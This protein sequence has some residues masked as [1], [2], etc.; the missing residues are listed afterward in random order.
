MAWTWTLSAAPVPTTAFLTSRAAYSPT[1]DARA[2]GDHQHDAA[3]LGEL[4]RR[5]RVLVDEDFLGRRAVRAVVDEH[6]LELRRE[7]GEAAR[8]AVPWRRS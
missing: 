7:V 2:G 6:R 5:L 8:E 1:V 3:R 4:E